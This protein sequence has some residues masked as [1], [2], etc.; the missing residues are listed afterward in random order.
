VGATRSPQ[1]AK[2]E[3]KAKGKEGIFMMPSDLVI[4]NDPAL[5]AIAKGYAA[6]NTKFLTVSPSCLEARDG[7]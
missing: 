5:A 4:K 2:V 3:F 6:D 1:Q 7:S